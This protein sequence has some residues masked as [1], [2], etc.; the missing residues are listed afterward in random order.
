MADLFLNSG[1]G[2]DANSGADWSNEKATLLTGIAGIDAAGD[3]ILVNSAHAET[4]A[5]NYTFPGTN[6][7][8]NQ[9]LSVTPTG[10]S[11]ISALTKGAA[12]NVSSGSTGLGWLGSF[13]AYGCVF[14]ISTSSSVGGSFGAGSTAV[15]TLE[16]CDFLMTSTGASGSWNFGSTTIGGGGRTVLVNP[17]FRIGNAGQRVVYHSHVII[18]GGQWS[19]SGTLNPAGVFAPTTAGRGQLLEVYGFDFSNLNA[20]INLIGGFQGGSAAKFYGCK[21]PASWTGAPIASASVLPGQRVEMYNCDSGDTN[22]RLWIRDYGGD[23]T[24]ET[25]YYRTGGA[26]DG[27]T[28]YSFKMTTTANVAWPA[29]SLYSQDLLI[30]NDTTGSSVTVTC[31]IEHAGVGGGTGGRLTDREAWLEVVGLATSGVP[32][33]TVSDDACADVITTAADQADSSESWAGS[34]GSAVKQKLAVTFTPQEKGWV[35]CRV[36]LAKPSVTMYFDPKLVKT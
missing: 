30:W 5:G 8:P 27:T 2:S 6:A 1:D 18:K 35:L 20:A 28:S 26:S 14:N 29:S 33:A 7:S 4:H 21:L 17:T 10:A 13:Y 24:T 22:Y 25:T 32:L 3:R 15:A 11:G 36:H 16:D 34:L 23:I 9:I 31:E 19:A 12:F